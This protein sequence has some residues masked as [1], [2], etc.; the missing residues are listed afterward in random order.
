MV[1]LDKIRAYN[2]VNLAEGY[3]MVQIVSPKEVNFDE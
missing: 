2:A 1:R 3:G